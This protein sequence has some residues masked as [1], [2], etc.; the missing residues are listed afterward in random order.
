MEFFLQPVKAENDEGIEFNKKLKL[1]IFK[2]LIFTTK[3]RKRKENQSPMYK[4]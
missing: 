2:I 1:K 4:V 3:K